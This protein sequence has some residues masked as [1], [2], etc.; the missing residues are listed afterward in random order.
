MLARSIASLR[1]FS[2]AFMCAV[3]LSIGLTA[4]T[5]TSAPSAHA[6]AAT[7][8]SKAY[9]ATGWF[10]KNP[11][12]EW[13]EY[14]GQGNLRYTFREIGRTDSAIKLY[15]K[16]YGVTV[17]LETAEQRIY[18]EWPGQPRHVMHRITNMEI[19][20]PTPV[21]TPPAAP[22]QTPPPPPSTTQVTSSSVALA[23]YSGGDFIKAVNTWTENTASGARNTFREIGHDD[24][25]VYLYDTTRGAFVILDIPGRMIR[26]TV[27]GGAVSDLY[28]VT[29]FSALSKPLS[30]PIDPP[31]AP[32]PPTPQEPEFPEPPKLSTL[33]RATCIATGGTV[34]QA[35]ILGA[36]RCTRPYHDGGMVC[37][38]SS[39]CQGKCIA[40]T[41]GANQSTTTGTCQ[42]TDNPFGCYAEVQNGQT[43]PALCVD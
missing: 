21:A 23:A 39:Q 2:G 34:E 28:P 40:G 17:E 5:V 43:G 3:F 19:M 29:E 24:R 31:T 25:H 38:D 42:Q 10:E 16:Q 32:P 15:L 33:E 20:A 36:E 4:A 41:D 30:L 26:Y 11:S 37:S 9:F 1:H 35:G 13:D 12:G 8:I 7:D 27:N 14:D 22:P 6:Q 18:A